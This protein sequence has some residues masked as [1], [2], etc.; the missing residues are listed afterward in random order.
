MARAYIV[1]ARNDL[2]E[3]G[4]QTLDL[5]P[6][7]S[8]KGWPYDPGEGQT[9]YLSLYLIDGINVN[10]ATTVGVMDADSYGLSTYLKANV[11]DQ[12]AGAALTDVQANGA[13]ADIEAAAAAG[14]PLTAADI[15]GHIQAQGG[16]NAG[17]TLTAG[18]STGS[19]EEILRILA[20]ERYKVPEGTDVGVAAF[21]PGGGFFTTAANVVETLLHSGGRK[22]TEP[23]GAQS[24]RTVAQTG[25]EDVNHNDI[26]QTID[27]EAVHRSAL[28]GRLAQMAD[29]SYAFSNP[30]FTYGAAGTA[31]TLGLVN[32]GTDNAARA[33]TVYA[34][35]GS[36]II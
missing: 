22:G 10:V 32:I 5:W 13:A 4:L 3:T 11:E 6:N 18:D 16:V 2:P 7:T 8:Q 31:L 24:G 19:V 1:L 15:N 21:I 12:A 29:S 23:I 28:D 33:V 9:G 35:D 27:T 36:V 25:T 26:R 34:D 17:T 20:G 30:D 14:D